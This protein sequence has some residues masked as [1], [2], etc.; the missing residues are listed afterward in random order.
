MSIA[1]NVFGDPAVI[2]VAICMLI[3]AVICV[4]SRSRAVVPSTSRSRWRTLAI[5]G[6]AA[7]SG[8]VAGVAAFGGSIVVSQKESL[9]EPLILLLFHI[10]ASGIF[11]IAVWLFILTPLAFYVPRHCA[12]RGRAATTSVS[13]VAGALVMSLF[14]VVIGGLTAPLVVWFFVL[15]A[16]IVGSVTGFV[17]NI[18]LD[19]YDTRANA[20]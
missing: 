1:A 3:G 12:L 9:A 18:L 11:V 15:E 7:L 10:Y 8:W 13:G 20:I 17:G 2:F 14:W 19:R 5:T 6:A 4:V 16:A